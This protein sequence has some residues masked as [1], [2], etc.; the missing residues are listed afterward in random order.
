ML[1]LQVYEL[2]VKCIRE[3]FFSSIIPLWLLSAVA[4]ASIIHF[5]GR[6]ITDQDQEAACCISDLRSTCEFII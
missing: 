6:R 1:S 5:V 4:E 2:D 3:M